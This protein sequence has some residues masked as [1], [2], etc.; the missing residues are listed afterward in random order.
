VSE[1]DYLERKHRRGARRR[2]WILRFRER[3]RALLEWIPLDEIPDWAARSVTGA[4]VA[5][6]EQARI[7]AYQRLDQ[8]A[9][10]GEF[11]ALCRRRRQSKILF[12][13]PDKTGHGENR[14]W[15]TREM[16]RY[17][18]DIRL[19]A[20]YCYLPRVLAR[21]WFAVHGY[22]W[23]ASLQRQPPQNQRL[24][25]AIQN[26]LRKL[27]EPPEEVPWK[28]F[29]DAVRVEGEV[30]DKTRGYGDRSILRAFNRM[31]KKSGFGKKTDTK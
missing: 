27:G 23:P 24:E 7:L 10:N 11:E 15:L 17:V 21:R 18:P 3:Q 29:C 1:E 31:R 8:S 9:R 25:A 20:P 22:S 4:D 13:H 16:L 30:A 26:A 2:Q 28:R 5:A 12:L 14:R 6:E 19:V